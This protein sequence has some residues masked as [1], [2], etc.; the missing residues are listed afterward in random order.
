MFGR[1]YNAAELVGWV[2]ETVEVRYMP[3]H[4]D[5]VE[6]FRAGQHLATAFLVDTMDEEGTRRLFAQRAEDARWLA[7][8]Q[9]A[10]ARRRR[11][12]FAPTKPSGSTVN[13]SSISATSTTTP[14]PRLPCCSSVV[15]VLRGHSL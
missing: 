8:Q 13:A 5:A 14:T 3:N 7:R 4:Y 11:Q 2:G 15:R 10:A 12:R 1:R 6:V 9:R